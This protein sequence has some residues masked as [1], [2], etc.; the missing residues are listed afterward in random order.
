MRHDLEANIARVK[1]HLKSRRGRRDL[2]AR[3]RLLALEDMLAGRKPSLTLVEVDRL[4]KSIYTDEAVSADRVYLLDNPMFAMLKKEPRDPR[5]DG[6]PRYVQPVEVLM[7]KAICPD[8]EEL[9][10]ITPNGADPKLTNRRQRLVLHKKPNAP[11]LCPGGG[12][13]V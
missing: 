9:V 5:F 4:L 8:C 1:A 10:E 3:W 11:E 7:P 2:K 6:P 13:D 12:K